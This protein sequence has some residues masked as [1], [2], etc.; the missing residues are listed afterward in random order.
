MSTAGSSEMTITKHELQQ[1]EQGNA[2]GR[3]PVMP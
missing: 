3:S 2:S 1:C